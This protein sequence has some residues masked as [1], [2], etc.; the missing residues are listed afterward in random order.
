MDCF[1]KQATCHGVKISYDAKLKDWFKP[2]DIVMNITFHTEQ[3]RNNGIEEEKLDIFGNFNKEN[4][5]W[6]GLLAIKMFFEAVGVKN[7]EYN[8]DFSIPQSYIDQ[9]INQQFLM[10]SY[11]TNK[12]NEKKTKEK[13]KPVPYWNNWKET[14]S[15]AKGQDKLKERFAQ[16]VSGGWVKNYKARVQEE[17][18]SSTAPEDFNTKSNGVIE[19]NSENELK[20]V[21]AGLTS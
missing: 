19:V 15:L 13:G 1:V 10:L 7:P 8:Q 9:A 12:L 14:T 21:L 5:T 18:Q 2:S 11:P 3:G 17:D 6:G 16:A 4:N 20:D